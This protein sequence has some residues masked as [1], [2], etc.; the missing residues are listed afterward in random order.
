MLKGLFDGGVGGGDARER[1]DHG[2]IAHFLRLVGRDERTDAVFD[3]VEAERPGRE[4]ADG[5]RRL[6]FGRA[7]FE[8]AHVG[9]DVPG[10]AEALDARV[11]AAGLQGV[12]AGDD[13]DVG[14]ELRG[15]EPAGFDALEVGFSVDDFLALQVAAAL[16]EDLVFDVE[17]GDAGEV[18]LLDGFGDD[19]GAA[20]AG[21]HVGDEWRAVGCQVRD[22]LGVCAHVVELGEAEVG[23]AEA[24]GGGTGAGHVHGFETDFEG[25]AG[26]E[27]VVDAGADDDA[28]GGLDHLAESG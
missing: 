9:A 10:A 21:V 19:H 20:V 12:G 17:A 5:L 28:G 1:E 6:R 2:S 3:A 25:D 24:G 11:V 14:A 18:V 27:A 23:G 7:A 16:L 8:D 15:G 22:H 13:D 4:V 26:G